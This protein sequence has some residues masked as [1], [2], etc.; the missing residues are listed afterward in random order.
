VGEERGANIAA[1]LS[2]PAFRLGADKDLKDTEIDFCG[3]GF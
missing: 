1:G 3:L 2:G